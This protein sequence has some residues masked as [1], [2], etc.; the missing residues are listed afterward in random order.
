MYLL[1]DAL[2]RAA[3]AVGD[4]TA[5]LVSA[6]VTLALNLPLN[7]LLSG[8]SYVSSETGFC[9]A[10]GP[11]GLVAATVLVNACSCVALAWRV[12]CKTGSPSPGTRGT[13]RHLYPDSRDHPGDQKPRE[14]A[15]APLDGVR[16]A[17]ALCLGSICGGIAASS[18][19]RLAVAA[20]GLSTATPLPPSPVPLVSHSCALLEAAGT[21][22]A[23]SVVSFFRAMADGLISSGGV[24]GASPGMPFCPLP[25]QT[26]VSPLAGQ[27]FAIC[28]AGSAGVITAAVFIVPATKRVSG[29]LGFGG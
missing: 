15:F 20:V 5:S 24:S 16:D 8:A 22:V 11:P 9:F 6:T 4:A 25:A 26:A 21:V 29:R 10:Y 23:D 3:L 17:L 18:V 14:P 27:L 28:A 1:R 13:S 2:L 19:M 7:V 12:R